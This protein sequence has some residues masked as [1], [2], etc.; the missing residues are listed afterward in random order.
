MSSTVLNSPEPRYA[1]ASAT[2]IK[3][4]LGDTVFASKLKMSESLSSGTDKGELYSDRL[5]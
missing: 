3:Q 5:S 4:V 1:I 2:P